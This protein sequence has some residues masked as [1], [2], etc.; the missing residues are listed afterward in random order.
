[1]VCGTCPLAVLAVLLYCVPLAIGGIKQG[2]D[3]NDA[4]KPFSDVMHSSLLF[5]RISTLG[6]LL[7]AGANLML[8]VNLLRI[9]ARAGRTAA[10][11][12]WTANTKTA[13]VR[14]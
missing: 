1:M 8:L 14:A 11:A 7:M 3:M 4:A 9:L 6:D 5:L 13:G 10:V 2:L 12:A